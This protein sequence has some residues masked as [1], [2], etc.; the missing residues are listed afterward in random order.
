MENFI[1]LTNEIFI[2]IYRAK[3]PVREKKSKL[4]VK[5]LVDGNVSQGF[6]QIASFMI[7]GITLKI[8]MGNVEA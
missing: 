5:H 7:M 3:L 6:S 2:L 8:P 1:P 4:E